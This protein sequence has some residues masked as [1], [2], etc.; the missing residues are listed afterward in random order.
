MDE[1]GVMKLQTIKAEPTFC[2]ALALAEHEAF[3]SSVA[4]LAG[5]VATLVAEW[6]D[7][8]RARRELARLDERMLHD[9]GINRMDAEFEASKPFWRA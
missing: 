7:R 9:I 8:V 1:D 3:Q 5:R 4:R 6:Q 2:A